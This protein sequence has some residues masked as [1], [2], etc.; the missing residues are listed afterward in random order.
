MLEINIKRYMKITHIFSRAIWHLPRGIFDL[1]I[2][3]LN[4]IRRLKKHKDSQDFFKQ[5][6]LMAVLLTFCKG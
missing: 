2:E 4:K 1:A 5:F 6:F 3:S